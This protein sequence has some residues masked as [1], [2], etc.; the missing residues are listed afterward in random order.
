MEGFIILFEITSYNA[1]EPRS[2]HGLLSVF[3]QMRSYP[4]E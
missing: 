4:I 3:G 1:Q 2:V